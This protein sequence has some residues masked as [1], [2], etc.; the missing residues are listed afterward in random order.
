MRKR[1]REKKRIRIRKRI[2]REKIGTEN[3]IEDILLREV[4]M[5]VA[6]PV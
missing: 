2:R 3:Q 1:K 6:N 4:A 5:K